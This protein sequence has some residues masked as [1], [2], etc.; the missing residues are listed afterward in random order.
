M[1]ISDLLNELARR[2]GDTRAVYTGDGNPEDRYAIVKDGALWRVY[3][4][5]RGEQLEL[6]QFAAEQDACDYLLLLLNKDR[7]VWSGT[8]S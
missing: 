4:T 7:T 2:G 8:S 3:Y 1:S 6:R 5:E